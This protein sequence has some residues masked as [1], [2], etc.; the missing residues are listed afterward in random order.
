M[1]GRFLGSPCPR[2]GST[3][4]TVMPF[5]ALFSI[6]GVGVAL[7]GIQIRL[8]GQ[9]R[10]QIRALSTGIHGDIQGLHARIELVSGEIRDVRTEL[11]GRI[12]QVRDELGGRIDQVSSDVKDVR[13]ELN[14]RIDKV[15]D[16]LGGRIDKVGSDVKDVRTELSGRIDKVSDEL[17]EVR[18]DVTFIKGHLSSTLAS[19]F[20]PKVEVT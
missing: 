5:S 15:R 10:D 7:M 9:V 20:A 19:G 2:V 8:S 6:F 14:G 3:A 13:T 16:E 1:Q 17:K 11:N 12:D 4:T 18:G